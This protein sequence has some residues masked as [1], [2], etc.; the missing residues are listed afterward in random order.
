MTDTDTLTV[1]LDPADDLRHALDAYAYTVAD[2]LAAMRAL[3]REAATELCAA[4]GD[5]QPGAVLPMTVGYPPLPAYP[6]TAAWRTGKAVGSAPRAPS[7]AARAVARMDR[8]ARAAVARLGCLGAAAWL[9]DDPDDLGLA[10][11][12]G[13]DA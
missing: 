7:P 4:L 1:T 9:A 6:Y 11:H 5:A 10:A 3:A 12:L 2:A 8:A 13:P